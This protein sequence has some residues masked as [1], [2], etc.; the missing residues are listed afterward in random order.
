MSLVEGLGALSGFS[1]SASCKVGQHNTFPR[2]K[3]PL[4]DGP[5]N[6][7]DRELKYTVELGF[8]SNTTLAFLNSKADPEHRVP[9][10]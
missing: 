8:R 1:K 6:L 10:T 9:R 2:V 4:G 5:R 7:Q 3:K